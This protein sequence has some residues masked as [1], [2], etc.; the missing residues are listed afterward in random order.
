M[1]RRFGSLLLAMVVVFAVTV[2]AIEKPTKEFQAIMQSNGEIIDLSAGMTTSEIAGGVNVKRTSL[3]EHMRKR[4]YDGIASDAAMLK[5][6]FLKTE[7][8]WTQRKIAT[9]IG[10]SKAG[11]KAATDLEAAAKA[12]D[13]AAVVRAHNA[14]V[15][16]CTDCHRVHRVLV[17][18]QEGVFV[19]DVE[20]PPPS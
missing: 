6:N 13:D 19:I 5:A 1:S 16:S 7:A 14:V 20:G 3:L 8:W 12:K 2:V 10:F 18:G 15:E 4:D 9:A 11:F 17:F